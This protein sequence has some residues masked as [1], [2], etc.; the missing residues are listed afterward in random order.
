MQSISRAERRRS[1]N[2]AAVLTGSSTRRVRLCTWRGSQRFF[3]RATLNCSAVNAPTGYRN[4]HGKPRRLSMMTGTIEVKRPRV[5]GL[6]QRF[7]S[8][9]LP[10]IV[11]RTETVGEVLPQLYLHEFAGR[12]RACVARTARRR[13]A[14]LG[15]VDR[16]AAG[17]VATGIRGLAR[18]AAGQA[19]SSVRLSR[20]SLCESEP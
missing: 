6:E 4:G 10:L 20:R 15:V 1:S 12:F 7:E 14:A 19:R 2:A 3:R 11:R 8:R 17:E 16:A 13:C 5:R 9:L 18:P